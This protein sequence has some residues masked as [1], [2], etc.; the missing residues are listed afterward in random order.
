M[1]SITQKLLETSE[2]LRWL[3]VPKFLCVEELLKAPLFRSC[4]PFDELRL[5]GIVRC[6]FGWGEEEVSYLRNNFLLE[7]GHNV[8]EH[9][10]LLSDV[11]GSKLG[12]NLSK[13]DM[14]VRRPEWREFDAH[15]SNVSA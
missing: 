9:G 15:G 5:Q 13:P 6:V 4:C 8:V 11:S 7:R 14:R 2:E 12:L 10:P 1:G 3:P